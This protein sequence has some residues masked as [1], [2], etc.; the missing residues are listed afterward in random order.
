MRRLYMLMTLTAIVIGLKAQPVSRVDVPF[1]G[2]QV[3]I[4][5]GQTAEQVDAWYKEMEDAGMTVCRIRMFQQYMQKDDGTWDFTLFDC[6]FDAAQRHHVKVYATLFPTTERTDIGGWK[7]PHDNAQQASFANFIRNAVTH[8]RNHP[9]LKGWVLINEPG[10]DGKKIVSDVVDSAWKDWQKHHPDNLVGNDGFPNL[11]VPRH[12]QFLYEYT[13]DYLRWIADEVKKYDTKHDIHVN[14]AN[15]FG[16]IGEY[17]WQSWQKFLTSLGG[18][19]HPTWHYCAFT[20]PQFT[21]AMT[22]ESEILKSGAGSLPWFMTE[23]Q[24]GNNTWSGVRCMC[25]TPQEIAQW[26]WTVIGTEGKGAIFWMLNPRSSGIEAGEWALL[27][28]QN[29]P[30]ERMKMASNV[31]NCIKDNEK[32]FAKARQQMSSI[33]IVYSKESFWAEQLT[34]KKEDSL[35]VRRPL[36]IFKSVAACYQALAGC[37]IQAGICQLDNYDFSKKDYTGRTII[38]SNQI[39]LPHYARQ[40]LERFVS[41]GGNLIVEGLTA[42]FDEHLH[43]NNTID[44]YWKQLF[45]GQVSEY[46]CRDSAFTVYVDGHEIPAVWQQ[47]IIAGDNK[48]FVSQSFGKGHVLWIPSCLVLQAWNSGNYALLSNLLVRSTPEV[49]DIRF[50]KY[51]D[52]VTLRVLKSGNDIITVCINKSKQKQILNIANLPNGLKPQLLFKLYSQTPFTLQAE[53]VQVVLWKN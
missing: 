47:G 35:E 36:A 23:I 38:L 9:A 34:S 8:Y 32:I 43:N 12:E 53:D 6:A 14:P 30:S 22:I 16:N 11:T 24:G 27:D 51:H 45:G 48:S 4:E 13:A 26:L 10:T 17:D 44:F 18:S 49:K 50:D 15:V 21:L 33:D 1:I 28:F 5:P 19:A 31:A 37:G 20:R 7:F 40:K 29:K 25:P 46:I 2:A 3:F 52:G 42:F 39:S 41:L